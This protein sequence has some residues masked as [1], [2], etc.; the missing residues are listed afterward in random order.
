MDEAA[1][2]AAWAEGSAM[3]FDAAVGYT[4]N[5]QMMVQASAP[6]SDAASI[7]SA[8]AVLTPREREVLGHLAQGLSTRQIAAALVI[9]ERTAEKHVANILA[10][11]AFASRAQVAA[12]A[13]QRGL[14]AATSGITGRPS[15]DVG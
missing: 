5:H 15:G 13:V 14:Y 12:W 7:P 3:D 8:L 11:L 4:L 9:T 10:K 2:A 1:F 6:A